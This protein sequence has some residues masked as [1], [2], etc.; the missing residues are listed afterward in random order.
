[1]KFDKNMDIKEIAKQ[2]KGFI[3]KQY[4]KVKEQGLS[5]LK[6]NKEKKIKRKLKQSEK[7]IIMI[8]GSLIIGYGVYQY[9]LTPVSEKHNSISAAE[10]ES[11]KKRDELEAN[12]TSIQSIKADVSMLEVSV[13]QFK[14]KYP[15][16]RTENEILLLLDELAS[17]QGAKVSTVKINNSVNVSKSDIATFIS[18]K[19]IG[20]YLK[21][22]NYF[23]VEKTDGESSS[24]DNNEKT[25]PTTG[26]VYATVS[27][28]IKDLSSEEALNLLGEIYTSNR[29]MLPESL[30]MSTLTDGKVSVD[31]ELYFYAY[32]DQE[33]GNL[34]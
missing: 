7:G 11:I 18:N 1:M 29:V 19:G 16:Y 20:P 9:Y 4:K 15:N 12:I 27:F 30:K 5:S 2:S 3:N 31:G 8:M 32:R 33:I 22:Q 17:R 23:V 24:N 14:A 26:F 6:P 25:E 34:F 21:N 28:S 10:V 13:E